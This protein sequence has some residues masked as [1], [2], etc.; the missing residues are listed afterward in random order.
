MD[1]F[2]PKVFKN[3][4]FSQPVLDTVLDTIRNFK[5]RIRGQIFWSGTYLKPF[6][7]SNAV[8]MTFA[9]PL[10]FEIDFVRNPISGSAAFF[11][12]ILKF[13]FTAIFEIKF[14]VKKI[15]GTKKNSFYKPDFYK[16]INI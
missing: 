13:I 6:I 16:P 14:H 4:I 7:K 1:R 5:I 8:G 3:L 11:L 10:G 15:L 9:Q 12:I 2:S